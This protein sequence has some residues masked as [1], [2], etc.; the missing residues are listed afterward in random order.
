MLAWSSPGWLLALA[1]I[2]LIW[3]LHRLTNRDSKLQVSTL[4]FWKPLFVEA[5][6]S[7]FRAKADP[8]WML[9][10]LIAGLMVISIAG[11][12]WQEN[13]TKVI[14]IWFDDSFSMQTL[15]N[16][17]SRSQLAIDRLTESL[18][19]L[20]NVKATLHSLTDQLRP[21]LILASG[22]E[23][24]WPEQMK[25][26][27]KIGNVPIQTPLLGKK[28]Q[29]LVSDGADR[30][31]NDWLPSAQI[32]HFLQ[33]GSATDNSAISLLSVRPNLKQPGIW[34]VVIRVTHFGIESDQRTLALAA[35]DKLLESK[36]VELKPN[37]NRLV[38]FAVS[39]DRLQ[40]EPLIARLAALDALPQDDELSLPVA[41]LITTRVAGNCPPPIV[42]AINAHPFLS[43]DMTKSIRPELDIVC[44]DDVPLEPADT[45]IRFHQSKRSLE[46][47]APPIWL[48]HGERLYGLALEQKH[49]TYFPPGQ[50]FQGSP[51][52]VA[53]QTPLITVSETT[54]RL[55][56]CF[57]DMGSSDFSKQPEYPMLFAGLV[58]LALDRHLLDNIRQVSIPVDESHI[59][60]QPL[61]LQA[62]KADV[63]S[64]L[65]IID[66]IPYL[67][68]V[69]ILLLLID[70]WLSRNKR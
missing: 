24:D 16:G 37:Q 61:E 11:P 65:N 41:M 36:D 17:I 70:G 4:L 60:P 54:P 19:Q 40:E 26:W 69:A 21:P 51:V 50:S 23:S 27:I 45:V 14:D 12:H 31:L 46:V 5:K 9:R 20:G 64:N 43:D 53:G 22:S 63:E 18:R 57:I 7:R 66:L 44:S 35:G 6:L 13:N 34:N 47:N 32:D 68:S 49:L 67:L 62:K 25:H 3:L 48:G 15:E 42:N 10:A 33:I 2:P 30:L 59:A 28:E 1:V 58:D 39:A 55:V 56:D 38:E 29:W 52:L 8:I